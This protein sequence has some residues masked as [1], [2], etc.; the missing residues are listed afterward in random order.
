MDT[1]QCASGL[2]ISN[3]SAVAQ[4]VAPLP[5]TGSDTAE[6]ALRHD[7]TEPEDPSQGVPPPEAGNTVVGKH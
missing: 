6:S 4:E 2:R 3:L 1:L 5:H 7:A